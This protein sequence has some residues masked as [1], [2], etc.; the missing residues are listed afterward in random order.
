MLSYEWEK[1]TPPPQILVL[2]LVVKA[3]YRPGQSGALVSQA[4]QTAE[5]KVDA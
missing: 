3:Q 4:K 1:Q 2:Y 5:D